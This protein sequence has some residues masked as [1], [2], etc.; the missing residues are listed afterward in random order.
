[1]TTSSDWVH[2]FAP[3]K[4]NL[5][6]HVTGQRSDGYHLLDSL[7]AFAD[8]GDTIRLR[9]AATMSLRVT[10]PMAEGVPED[11]SNLVW[12]AADWLGTPPVEIELEKHLP[13]A[14][15]IGGGSSDAAATLRALCQ[16]FKVPLPSAKDTATLGA[17][18]P[19]CLRGTPCLMRGIGDEIAPAPD[20]PDMHLLLV[21]PGVETPTPTVFRAL[22]S[23]DNSEMALPDTA[24]RSDREAM[25]WVKSQRNDLEAP[26][27]AGA[28][29]IKELLQVLEG[30]GAPVARM[31]GSGATC[32]VA[33]HRY[34]DIAL[35]EVLVKEAFPEFWMGS[36]RSWALS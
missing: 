30:A 5:T 27:I 25:L 13:S 12:K 22:K 11:A 2:A 15:G 35:A 4:I 28:P 36:A 31:S 24:F 32:F 21:N 8:I 23:K 14:A 6:L 10:G 34:S 18:V 33:S 7:V 20:L 9:P 26:A 29:I 1:M 19:V 17:D 16:L 3:A